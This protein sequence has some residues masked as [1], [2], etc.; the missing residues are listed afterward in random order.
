MCG[1]LAC[2]WPFFFHDRQGERCLLR[3]ADK[4]HLAVATG[5]LPR[6]A[7][8]A[9]RSA[10]RGNRRAVT[11]TCPAKTPDTAPGSGFE[12]GGM[13]HDTSLA[14]FVQAQTAFGIRG[15]AVGVRSNDHARY[16]CHGV[17]SIDNPSHALGSFA[18]ECRGGVA[19]PSPVPI[20]GRRHGRESSRTSAS[21][22]A[23]NVGNVSVRIAA[24]R[25]QTAALQ[26][27]T[28]HKAGAT[29]PA[30]S[31]ADRPPSTPG[32]GVSCLST[33]RQA[34]PFAETLAPTPRRIPLD[35]PQAWP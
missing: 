29:R 8:V 28:I 14:D 35:F 31:M 23:R 20:V 26:R 7:A 10:P 1:W 17:T 11:T 18:R 9:R 27:L 19:D 25:H 22:F 34:S 16:A 33:A 6:R 21:K 30:S 3:D 2:S 12:D 4:D 13:S 32:R 24:W 5:F 15:V